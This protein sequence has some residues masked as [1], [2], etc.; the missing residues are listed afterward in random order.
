MG[1]AFDGAE[2]AGGVFTADAY[3]YTS[4][5]TKKTGTC[6]FNANQTANIGVKVS[7]YV[8][9]PALSSDAIKRAVAT[10]GPISVGVDATNWGPYSTGIFVD[11]SCN[12]ARINHAVLVVGYGTEASTGRDYWIVK[13]SWWDFVFTLEFLLYIL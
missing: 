13:N 1:D 12:V 9:L 6:M 8:T 3:P 5:S 4:G 10:I 2:K 7:G 11:P